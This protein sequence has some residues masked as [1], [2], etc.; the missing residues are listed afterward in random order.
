MNQARPTRER[1]KKGRIEKEKKIDEKIKRQRG[2]RRV[3]AFRVLRL[4]AS[5][6]IKGPH[7]DS[8]CTT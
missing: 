8:D 4:P 5:I 3:E 1:R 7:M 6:T 2:R